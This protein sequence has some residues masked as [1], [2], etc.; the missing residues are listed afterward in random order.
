MSG[1]SAEFA[2][3]E[4][5]EPD[6]NSDRER[7]GPVVLDGRVNEVPMS[8]GDISMPRVRAV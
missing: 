1:V 4:R 5:L 7:L 8:E 2:A 6:K 3:L